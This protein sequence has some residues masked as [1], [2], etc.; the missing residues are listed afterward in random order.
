MKWKRF[1]LQE[2]G[3]DSTLWETS[4]LIFTHLSDI[5]TAEGGAPPLLSDRQ[6]R[7]RTDLAN[8]LGLVEK[9][10]QHRIQSMK[11]LSSVL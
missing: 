3:R 11:T 4:R 9:N 6:T 2:N 5:L 10:K 8:F 1:V 7:N